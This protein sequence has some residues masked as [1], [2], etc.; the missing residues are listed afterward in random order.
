ML[1]RSCKNSYL[2][3][4]TL[5]AIIT[6]TTDLGSTDHYVAALKGTLLSLAPSVV[7][8]DITHDIAPFNIMEAAFAVRSVF[9]RFPAGTIHVIGVDPEGGSRR[10]AIV[11]SWQGHLFVAPDNGVMSLI[12]TKGESQCRLVMREELF[13]KTGKAFLASNFYVPVAAWLANGGR[14]EDIG[15]EYEMREFFWGEPTYS[16]NSLRGTILHIDRFGNAITNLRKDEFMR[17]KGD[18]SFQIFIRNLR[19][20]RIVSSYGDVGRGEALALFSD[21]GHLEIAL[22][23]GSAA[24]L[25]GLKEQDMLTIEFYE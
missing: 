13:P 21:S 15:D 8:V 11:C 24:Q 7:S 22:R 16:E 1:I 25:L 5:M 10:T 6:L 18:R 14:F 20:Q 2:F 19:L 23:E 17:I 3:A 4:I 9:S 12:R